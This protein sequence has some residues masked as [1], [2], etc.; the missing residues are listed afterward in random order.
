MCVTYDLSD[1][2]VMYTPA[3]PGSHLILPS[4]H[5]PVFCAPAPRGFLPFIAAF[6]A[7]F[8]LSFFLADQE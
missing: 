2:I 3:I 4:G 5:V 7:P 1:E 8:F 6:H